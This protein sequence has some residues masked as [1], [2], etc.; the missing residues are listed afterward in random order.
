M[1]TTTRG[2]VAKKA[3]VLLVDDHPLLR[4][5]L[6]RLIND[7]PDLMVCGEAAGPPE[8]IAQIQ[9]HPPELIVLDITLQGGD[10]L[11]LCKQIHGRWPEIPVLVLSMHDETLYA[12]RALRAGASGYIMKQ[13]PQEQ[14]LTAMRRAL[15]GDTYLSEAMS[16]RLLRSI[17]GARS[18]A[19]VTP[20]ER[21]SDRELEIFRL[22]GQGQSVKTIA[23][24]LFLSPKT[25]EAHKEHI[26][27]KL[28]LKSS[29]ELLQY[30]IQATR[31]SG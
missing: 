18:G 7:Q 8:A 19:E 10:G 11:E 20:L 14:V 3:A 12:E 26:K 30:A 6:A 27:Q 25:V 21:L 23:Q 17:R 31:Q 4:Q 29:N 5:G 22:I 28:D 16:A 13:E 2:D 24:S 15:R 1:K 9:R